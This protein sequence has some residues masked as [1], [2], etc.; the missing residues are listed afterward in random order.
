MK[1]MTNT[2]FQKI[3]ATASNYNLLDTQ[4]LQ[5]QNEDGPIWTHTGT[6]WSPGEQGLKTNLL[7]QMLWAG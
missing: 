5:S 2:R 7:S 3:I 6:A 1:V 4:S